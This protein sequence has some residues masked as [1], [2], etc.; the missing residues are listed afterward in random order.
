M[1]GTAQDIGLVTKEAITH[2]TDKGH[3]ITLANQTLKKGKLMTDL[4]AYD[5]LHDLP[6]SVEIESDIEVDSHPEHVKLNMT[7][8]QDLGFGECHIWSKNAKIQEIYDSLNDGEKQ[9]VKIFL[10]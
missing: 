10:L 9:S 5:Y 3:F 8:W 4:V 7:K 1:I 6:I 2:Y